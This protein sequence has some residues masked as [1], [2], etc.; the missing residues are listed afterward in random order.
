MTTFL[1]SRWIWANCNKR[2]S[3]S[4]LLCT[5]WASGG[6]KRFVCFHNF[7]TV[8]LTGVKMTKL[9]KAHCSPPLVCEDNREGE[10]KFL[11]CLLYYEGALSILEPAEFS[12]INL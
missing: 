6:W 8:F 11:R 10:A 7:G 1:K 2:F 5:Y 4:F 3:K 12:S 9:R